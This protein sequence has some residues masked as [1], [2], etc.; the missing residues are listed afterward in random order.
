MP[1]ETELSLD[2]SAAA[3]KVSYLIYTQVLTSSWSFA[4]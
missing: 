2:T 3:V 1:A 4:M